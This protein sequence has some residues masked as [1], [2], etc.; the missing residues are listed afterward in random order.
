MHKCSLQQ[1]ILE[2]VLETN[3]VYK[4]RKVKTIML[5]LTEQYVATKSLR[6]VFYRKSSVSF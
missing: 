1:H 5:Y 4:E 3:N 6:K 2:N